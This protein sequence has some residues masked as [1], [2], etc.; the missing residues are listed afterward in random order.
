MYLAIYVGIIA[1]N[2]IMLRVIMLG[3]IMTVVIMPRV[4]A[5]EKLLTWC[6]QHYKPAWVLTK[7]SYNHFYHFFKYVR[8]ILEDVIL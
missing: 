4:V 8:Y 2:V 1:L 6:Q 5:P 7:L 3:V